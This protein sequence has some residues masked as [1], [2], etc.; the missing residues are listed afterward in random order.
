MR[1]GAGK[2]DRHRSQV[3]ELGFTFRHQAQVESYIAAHLDLLRDRPTV[4]RHGDYHPGNLVVDGA[5][6]CGVV[7]FNRC[8]WGD[9]TEEFYKVAFFGAPLSQDFA[10]G[11][12]EAYFGGN[13]PD[14]FWPLYNLHLAIA[15][16]G[17]LSWTHRH[18]PQYLDTSRR[19]IDLIVRTHDFGGGGPPTWW[20]ERR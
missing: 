18:W 5:R 1:S 9:P 4:C 6:L 13:P 2:Y 12:I 10:C 14:D 7:D 15:L 17:D 3:Q 8:D 20:T 16:F 19:L 11:Q